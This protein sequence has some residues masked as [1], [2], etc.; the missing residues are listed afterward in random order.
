MLWWCLGADQ[1]DRFR[2][3]LLVSGFSVPICHWSP[4]DGA[5]PWQ[6]DSIPC[7]TIRQNKHSG[8]PKL[9]KR[10]IKH[11]SSP[12]C[13]PQ[14]SHITFKCNE[15]PQRKHWHRSYLRTKGEFLAQKVLIKIKKTS[16]SAT[17]KPLSV[18]H[19]TVHRLEFTWERG[20]ALAAACE[21]SAS[22][23]E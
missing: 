19:W 17:E 15:T 21:G 3:L 13:L 23:E 14:P 7:S 16:A 20:D 5:S 2:L 22:E 4:W 12:F 8:K 18:A 9:I 11:S 1:S 6:K 10:L